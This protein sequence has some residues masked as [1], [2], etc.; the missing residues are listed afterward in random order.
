MLKRMFYV[1]AIM[2]SGCTMAVGVNQSGDSEGERTVRVDD[3]SDNT[4]NN[5]SNNSV[6]E[7]GNDNLDEPLEFASL[8]EAKREPVEGGDSKREVALRPTVQMRINSHSEYESGSANKES[9][10]LVFKQNQGDIKSCYLDV[11]NTKGE[12]KGRFILAITVS[13]DG[14]VVSVEKVEDEI[15]GEMFDCIRTR[16]MNWNFG[17]LESPITFRKTWVFS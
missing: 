6:V 9:I 5:A 12:S 16:I 2:L 15:G 4:K 17:A 7:S 10:E 11:M 8:D 14:T 3:V 13:K 1:F